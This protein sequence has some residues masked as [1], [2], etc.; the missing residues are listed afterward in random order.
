MKH[1]AIISDELL[2]AYIDHEIDEA[3][4]RRVETALAAE[5]ALQHRL[6]TLQTTVALM[7]GAPALVV[8]RALTLSESQV[9]AAGGRVKGVTHPTFWERW[10]P[11]LMPVATAVVAVM[12]VFSLVFSLP[13]T[14]INT[15]KLAMREQPAEKPTLAGIEP[16]EAPAVMASDAQNE[17]AEVQMLTVEQ[18]AAAESAQPRPVVS[19]DAM[20]VAREKA[21]PRTAIAETSV[22]EAAPAAKPAPAE[23]TSREISSMPVSWITWLL[24]LLLILTIFLTWQITFV[25]PRRR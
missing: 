15:S 12:F 24:G 18:P 4:L 22:P 7:K 6:E 10:L 25:R 21:S 17:A 23:P 1:S 5:P 3:E 9:L 20:P 11:R 19:E 8:P 13:T 14:P 16:T 2:S